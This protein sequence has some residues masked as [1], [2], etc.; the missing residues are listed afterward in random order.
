MYLPDRYSYLQPHYPPMQP[1]Q[2]GMILFIRPG[3][4]FAILF[5]I[6]FVLLLLVLL[7][8]VKIDADVPVDTTPSPAL[9]DSSFYANESNVEGTNFYIPDDTGWQHLYTPQAANSGNAQSQYL[10]E[11]E[12]AAIKKAL[13]QPSQT[14][15]E[16]RVRQRIYPRKVF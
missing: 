13:P 14:Q 1:Y 5:F 16:G 12:Q 10:N 6:F 8:M 9:V 15:P 7:F 3:T 11:G 2:S 4:I